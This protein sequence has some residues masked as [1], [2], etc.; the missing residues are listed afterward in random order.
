MSFVAHVSWF[1]Y[2]WVPT[3]GWGGIEYSNLYKLLAGSGEDLFLSAG[4][5][6][7]VRVLKLFSSRVAFVVMMKLTL[8]IRECKMYTNDRMMCTKME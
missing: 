7:Q 4:S 3:R 8:D 2:S 6:V 1:W 5:C